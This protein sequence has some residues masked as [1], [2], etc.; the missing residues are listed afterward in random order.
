MLMERGTDQGYFPEP[1]KYLSILDT[2]GQEEAVRREF[3]AEALLLHFVSG[4]RYLGAYLG[5]Q[6]E[7]EAWAKP[8]V[9]EWAHGVR[10]LGKYPD[11]TPSWLMP[12]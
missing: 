1:A 6:E 5:P 8:Q 9:E 10:V 12:A 7:L 4:S 11:D 2:P 3:A